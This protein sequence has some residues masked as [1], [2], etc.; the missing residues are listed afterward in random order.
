MKW[1]YL[2]FVPFAVLCIV[3]C[4]YVV[5]RSTVQE[6]EFDH[7]DLDD[8]YVEVYRTPFEMLPKPRQVIPSSKLKQRLHDYLLPGVC[9]GK[10][11]DEIVLFALKRKVDDS[12]VLEVVQRGPGVVWY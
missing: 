9:I 8:L 11:H 10:G 3:C 4:V 2:L 6:K 12:V 5:R 1:K 7:L